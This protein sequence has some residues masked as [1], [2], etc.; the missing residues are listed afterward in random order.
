MLIADKLGQWN[1]AHEAESPARARELSWRA[2]GIGFGA[3]SAATTS[4]PSATPWMRWRRGMGK[5]LKFQTY[6]QR[7]EEKIDELCKVAYAHAENWK[8]CPY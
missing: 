8:P 2:A 7:I 6:E 5:I 4:A 1:A 3:R